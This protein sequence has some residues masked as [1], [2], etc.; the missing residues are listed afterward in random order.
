MNVTIIGAGNVGKRLGKLISETRSHQVYYGVK[1]KEQIDA[2]NHFISIEEAIQKSEIIFFTI[3]F[4]AYEKLLPAIAPL[5]KGK[6]VVDVT[7]PL[8][9]DWSPI[10]LGAEDSA[11]EMVQR[12]LPESQVVKAFNTVF[13]DI[14]TPEKLNREGHKTSC[15]IA[16]NFLEA[17]EKIEQLANQMGLNA[18][19]AGDL[20]NARYFEAIAHLNIQL[21][22]AQKGGTDAAFVY[23]R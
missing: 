12:L 10:V 4:V 15:F 7:N 23:M 22:V 20:K 3:P 21:A 8:N 6:T 9:S 14:M 11:G 16:S 13:A 5:L 2:K 19:I 1:E 17:A 18:I